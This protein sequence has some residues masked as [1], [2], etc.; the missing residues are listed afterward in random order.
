MFQ[1]EG[2]ENDSS[3]PEAGTEA[4]P[5]GGLPIGCPQKQKGQGNCKAKRERETED[6]DGEQEDEADQKPMN[7]MDERSCRLRGGCGCVMGTQ[8]LGL[9]GRIKRSGLNRADQE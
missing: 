3:G 1:D 6:Q 5:L 8:G 4:G 2:E 9:L 7:P